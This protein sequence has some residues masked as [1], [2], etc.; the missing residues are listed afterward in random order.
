MRFEK[1]S[2]QE[3]PKWAQVGASEV[4]TVSRFVSQTMEVKC[5]SN[6]KIIQITHPKSP[7]NALYIVKKD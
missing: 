6:C 4:K 1:Y 7:L 2:T 3:T 5:L